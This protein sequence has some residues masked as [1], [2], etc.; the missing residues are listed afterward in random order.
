VPKEAAIEIKFWL[1]GHLPQYLSA[2]AAGKYPGGQFHG[3]DLPEG[4]K[5]R[6]LIGHLGIP[7]WTVELVSLNGVLTHDL[8]TPLKDGDAVGLFPRIL[9]GG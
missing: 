5:V 4:L 1:W 7:D 2:S 3:V 8:E 9:A 6:E